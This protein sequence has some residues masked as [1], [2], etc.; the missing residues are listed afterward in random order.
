LTVPMVEERRNILLVEDTEPD[1]FLVREALRQAGLEFDLKVFDDGEKAVE[2]IE[3]LDRDNGQTCPHLVLLDLNLP[4]RTGEQVLERMRQS[5][6]CGELPVII[7]TSSDSPKDKART[8]RLGATEYFRKPSRL[9]EFM[10]LGPLV[11]DLL[12]RRD[13][14]SR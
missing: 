2:F 1:V 14:L 8:S 5:P 12:G 6:R 11:R 4:K 9:D 3:A 10:K 13:G 7:V